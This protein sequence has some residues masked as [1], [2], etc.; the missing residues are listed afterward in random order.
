[1]LAA[2]EG[3]RLG[4]KRLGERE[5]KDVKKVGKKVGKRGKKTSKRKKRK[6]TSNWKGVA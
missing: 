2:P 4:Q 1:L 5:G 3:L 6:E